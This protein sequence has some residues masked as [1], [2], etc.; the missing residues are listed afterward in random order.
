MTLKFFVQ[1]VRLK[2]KSGDSFLV[3]LKTFL[4]KGKLKISEGN[5]LFYF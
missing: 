4:T 2:K 1:K 5:K 3:H